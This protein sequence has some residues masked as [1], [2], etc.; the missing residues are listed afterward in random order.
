[1]RIL[2]STIIMK[3]VQ[4]LLLD[5]TKQ[6]HNRLLELQSTG[7]FLTIEVNGFRLRELKNGH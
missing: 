2:K 1:M 5:R 7:K 3:K 4:I 6:I